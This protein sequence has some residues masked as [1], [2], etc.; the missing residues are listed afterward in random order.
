MSIQPS[1]GAG[2]ESPRKHDLV[3]DPKITTETRGLS[4]AEQEI[5]RLLDQTLKS[6][7]CL[8]FD[9]SEFEE[10]LRDLSINFYE[11]P[12]TIPPEQRAAF[13]EFLVQRYA[14]VADD[15]LDYNP[16]VALTML[17]ALTT[18]ELSEARYESSR[19]LSQ[20]SLRI[21]EQNPNADPITLARIRTS[22]LNSLLGE[23]DFDEFETELKHFYA[24]LASGEMGLS[25][26][27]ALTFYLDVDAD[28]KEHVLNQA[29]SARKLREEILEI[30]KNY[31]DY[32][33]SEAKIENLSALKRL[34]CQLQ[35]YEKVTLFAQAMIATIQ[36]DENPSEFLEDSISASRAASDAYFALSDY[37]KSLVYAE[38]N[39]ELVH[40]SYEQHSPQVFESSF[41]VARAH[42]GRD[43]HDTA[44]EMCEELLDAIDYFELPNRENKEFLVLCTL[45]EL[46][47]EQQN[48]EK[49]AQILD[50]MRELATPDSALYSEY[51]LQISLQGADL[52]YKRE[53]FEDAEEEVNACLGIIG[54]ELGH[55]LYPQ[56]ELIRGS[57]ALA[58]RGIEEGNK[59][60]CEALE[61]CHTVSHSNKASVAELYFLLANI[62]LQSS[63]INGSNSDLTSACTALAITRKV[64]TRANLEGSRLYQD[65][66]TQLFSL[67]QGYDPK[68]RLVKLQP[69]F[70]R[71][72]LLRDE[73]Q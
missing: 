66:T 10:A 14:S 18:L 5:L 68:N 67:L 72:S 15:L 29:H 62:R 65:A 51:M 69:E 56:V 32:V 73:D 8:E 48:L 40:A 63:A 13:T 53:N 46:E 44:R 52:E 9:S 26:K 7:V 30:Y 21:C 41:L 60:V 36:S 11:L 43:Q 58:H 25:E 34:S 61:T 64:L 47:L 12:Q 17:E 45:I 37:E 20:K 59:V 42:L 54:L 6:L 19:Q 31:P 49:A 57:I 23:Q 28:L 4:E 2:K 22:Y 33:S 55:S 38:F 24:E 1:E 35:D 3:E 27:L 50:R 16:L 71:L 70:E 39:L